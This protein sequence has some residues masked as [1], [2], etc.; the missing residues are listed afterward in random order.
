[1]N[2][3]EMTVDIVSDYF[4]GNDDMHEYLGNNLVE[5]VVSAKWEEDTREYFHPHGSTTS[6][7]QRLIS[8]EL[9][10]IKLNGT[11]L[12]SSNTPADFPVA[13]IVELAASDAFRIE[14]ERGTR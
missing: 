3:R 6:T 4:P 13:A 9:V 10:A 14:L 1:M 5:A 11:M 7:F 8:W 12:V 2:Y